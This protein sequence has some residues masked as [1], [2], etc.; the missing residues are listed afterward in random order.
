MKNKVIFNDV[1]D[2]FGFCKVVIQNKN[3]K[4]VGYSYCAPEDMENFSMYA[5]TRYA[6]IRAAAAAVKHQLKEE[7][8]KLKTIQNLIKDYKYLN[9]KVDRPI[10]IKLRDYAT[11]VKQLEKTYDAL[12]NSVKEQDKERQAILSRTK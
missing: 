12:I 7:K 10:K 1:D 11:N 5:G 9:K 2:R 6:E 4:F 3:G 8:I